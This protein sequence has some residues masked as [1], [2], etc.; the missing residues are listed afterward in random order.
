MIQWSNSNVHRSTASQPHQLKPL[1]FSFLFFLSF[2]P[3]YLIQFFFLLSSP[4]ARAYASPTGQRP[5]TYQILAHA[6]ITHPYN[7]YIHYPLPCITPQLTRPPLIVTVTVTGSGLT[8]SHLPLFS[9]FWFFDYYYHSLFIFLIPGSISQLNS[10]ALSGFQ[11][12]SRPHVHIRP[13]SSLVFILTKR[14][15]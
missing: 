4:R 11:V 1:F 8:S 7:T 2:F 10:L 9:D 14:T 3:F 15:Y 12:F 6:H 13:L 5:N